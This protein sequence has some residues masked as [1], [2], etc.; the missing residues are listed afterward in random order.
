MEYIGLL[1]LMEIMDNLIYRN[2]FEINT[3]FK[4]KDKVKPK[5]RNRDKLLNNI[6]VKLL[7]LGRVYEVLEK[8]IES[9][10]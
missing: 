8:N 6:R 5:K 3:W 2:T 4:R 10:C 1:K 7:E 9:Y